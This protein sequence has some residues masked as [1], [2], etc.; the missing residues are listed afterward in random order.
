MCTIVTVTFLKIFHCQQRRDIRH[1]DYPGVI[2]DHV[3]KELSIRSNLIR[4]V[5][6]SNQKIFEFN[7]ITP[8]VWPL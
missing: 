3:T 6:F 8:D 4:I 1:G 7:F 2:G 5:H